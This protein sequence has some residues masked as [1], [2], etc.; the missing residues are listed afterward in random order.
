MVVELFGDCGVYYVGG[1]CVDYGDVIGF[2]GVDCICLV[3]GL[4]CC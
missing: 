2:Y 4:G 3:L 1:V